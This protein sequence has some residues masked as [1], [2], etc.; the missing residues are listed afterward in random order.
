M[1]NENVTTV[2][3]ETIAQTLG[4]DYMQSVGDLANID[5]AKLVDIG[6]AIQNTNG[7][8]NVNLGVDIALK[9]MLDVIGR[10]ILEQK[11]YQSTMPRLWIDNREWG[12]YLVRY[13]FGLGNVMNDEMW[14]PDGF[15]DYFETGGVAEAQRISAIEH[16]YYKVPVS[17][18][19]FKQVF[20]HMIP[21][22]TLR[23]QFFT[24]FQSM[25]QLNEFLSAIQTSIQNTIEVLAE[26]KAHALVCSG[27]AKAHI[28]Q[29]ERNL[30]TEFNDINGT[31]LT[32]VQAL[33]NKDFLAYALAEIDLVRS[34]FRRITSAYS[35]SDNNN[36]SFTTD[37]DWRLMLLSQFV[38]KSKFLV[39]ANTFNENMLGIGDYDEVTAWQAFTADQTTAFDYG[40]EATVAMTGA[41]ASKLGGEN[42]NLTISNVIGVAYDRRAM[43]ITLNKEKATTQYTASRDSWN[44]F[45]HC[46]FEQI[47]DDNFKIVI[48]RIA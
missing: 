18:K 47:L 3:K 14:N 23:D 9:T 13:Y 41:S 15:I 19:V 12:G 2:L 32:A 17:G 38:N 27:I 21:I 43:G 30:L 8:S 31:S 16:G 7:S 22:T 24:A 34:N 20:S 5:S 42:E 25:T 39:R 46:I 37:D 1:T 33:N 28:L 10:I 4:N 35:N 29:N 26:A 48:F 36:L 45:Y 11:R 44:S 40:T 6:T